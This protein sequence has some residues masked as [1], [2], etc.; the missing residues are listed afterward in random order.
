[1]G[2]DNGAL[3]EVAVPVELGDAGHALRVGAAADISSLSSERRAR[4]HVNLARAHA[5]RRQVDEAVAALLE[6]E[7]ITSEQI[8]NQ[9]GKS[10][11][12]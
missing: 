10:R 6:A 2:P 3:Y 7:S 8:H 1:M 12:R 5:Q 4:L 9:A 11:P